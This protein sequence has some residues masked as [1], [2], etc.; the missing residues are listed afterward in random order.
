VP[1]GSL[2]VSPTDIHQCVFRDVMYNPR[3]DWRTCALEQRGTNFADCYYRE[4][5]EIDDELD[6]SSPSVENL[7]SDQF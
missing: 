1:F 6:V 2:L 5:R 4:Q 3:D 7:L